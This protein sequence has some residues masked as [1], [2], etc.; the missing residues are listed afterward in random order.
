VRLQG[1]SRSVSVSTHVAG[2]MGNLAMTILGKPRLD[3]GR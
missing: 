2:G 3:V 1:R